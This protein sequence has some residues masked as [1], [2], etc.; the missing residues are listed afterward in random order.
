MV[1]ETKLQDFPSAWAQR[2]IDALDDIALPSDLTKLQ[3][4]SAVATILVTL[5]LGM[6]VYLLWGVFSSLFFGI[7]ILRPLHSALPWLSIFVGIGLAIALGIRLRNAFYE[8]PK[9]AAQLRIDELRRALMK[10]VEHPEDGL[11]INDSDY[12]QVKYAL[13]RRFDD[14]S[15]SE[16]LMRESFQE[17]ADLISYL[18]HDIKTPLASIIGYLSMLAEV[19]ELTPE[20]REK[21]IKR[22][23]DSAV[24]LDVLVSEFF[25][26]TKFGLGTIVI[27]KAPVDLAMMIQQ[28]A[29]E[30]YPLAEEHDMRIVV[31]GDTDM[32]VSADP[33]RIGR[34]FQNLIKNA[35]SYGDPGTDITCSM[36]SFPESVVVRVSN[37]APEMTPLQLDRIFRKFYRLGDAR[38]TATG[39]SGLGLPIAREIVEQ[40]EG[41]IT[42]QS[43]EGI[44]TFTVTL[45]R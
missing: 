13:E 14:W 37:H 38:S 42:A 16:D 31:E 11:V 34:V 8:K 41:S 22:V 36:E 28:I 30:H 19:Q 27:D 7:I 3:V 29:D 45:V 25:D 39:G 5:A 24:K 23:L 12:L 4:R 33:E 17:K 18:A 15:R 6:L 44:V 20:N 43:S 2:Y 10:F 26:V 35:I 21:Y 32:T 1:A 9:I 40:H